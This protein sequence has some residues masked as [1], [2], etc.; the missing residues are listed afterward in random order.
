MG[1]TLSLRRCPDEGVDELYVRWGHALY[2][3]YGRKGSRSEPSRYVRTSRY[4]G[5]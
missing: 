1:F 2:L 5:R 4:V 3:R